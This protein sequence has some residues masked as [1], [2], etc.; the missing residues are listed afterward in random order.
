MANKYYGTIG[1]EVQTESSPGVWTPS[2]T[3]RQYF[4]DI[5]RNTRKWQ[6]GEHLNSNLNIS[7]SFSIVMD[8][9]AMENFHMIR[10]IEWMGALWEV[11]DV[12]VQYPR[13]ILSVGGVYNG[14]QD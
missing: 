12:E 11:T 7:N 13:L 3:K 14:P 4:G 1:F 10:F 6:S 8:P 9:Y 2:I 5:L